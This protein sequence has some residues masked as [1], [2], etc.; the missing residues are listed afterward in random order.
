MP[1]VP[2]SRATRVTSRGEGVELIDHGVDGVLQLENFAA[3]VDCDFAREIAIG[4]G[5]GDFGD[6]ADLGG[7]VAGHGIHGIGQ[8][9]PDAADASHIGLAAELAFGTDFAGDA[10]HFAGEG[11]E[12]IDHGVDGVLQFENF[13]AHIDGDFARKIAI[14]DGG[15][16]F[17]DVADL[18]RQVSGHGVDALGQIFPDAA[19]ALHVGLAAEFSFGA[20]FAGHARDFA[21][22]TS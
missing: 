2:T 12:L 21:R 17:G 20:D 9:F 8:I 19:D 16:H 1:S 22:R 5:G 10:R 4:D 7:Q 18:G 11:I 14:G 15:G 6:V 13:A 3:H